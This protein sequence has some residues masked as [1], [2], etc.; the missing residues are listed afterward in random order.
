M[1]LA[2]LFRIVRRGENE[3]V[4]FKKKINHPEKV[5]REVV[6]FANTEGG[7]LLV[8]ISD[9]GTLSGLK[10]PKEEEYA[11]TKAIQELCK[12][13]IQF[14]VETIDLKNNRSVLHYQ[15]EP[16]ATKPYYAFLSKNHRLGKAYIRVHDQSLQASKELRKFLQKE[17]A[18][19]T[20]G[21]VY[22]DHQKALINYLGEHEHITLREFCSLT[23]LAEKKASEIVIDLAR[24]HVIRILPREK[25]DW[26]VFAE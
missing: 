15:I 3:K 20:Q 2:E 25:E 17:S 11:L 7:H 8:G 18:K 1:E 14:Q 26:Y 4:E 5:V 10:F 13:D 19:S 23:H 9:D 24:N 22:G 16:G 6:A 12:P 21:F